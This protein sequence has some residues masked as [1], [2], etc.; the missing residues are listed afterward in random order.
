MQVGSFTMF[1]L[2]KPKMAPDGPVE[3]RLPLE[4][5]APVERLYALIDWDSPNNAKRELGHHVEPLA[6]RPGEY[7]LLFNGLDDLR[8]EFGV[9]EAKP[10]EAYEFNCEIIPPV[11]LREHSIERY[12]FEALGPDRCRVTLLTTVKFKD[13]L[14]MKD[15]TAELHRMAQ[16]S[17]DAMVK[18][19]L[20]A[21]QGA[22]AV[23]TIEQRQFG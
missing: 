2:F 17:A 19:K 6:G 3:F 12:E 4:V 14:R 18:F 21:E 15:F 10:C 11:G 13:G 20:H 22:Q 8:F 23:R 5:D 16:A 7:L 9:T 1:G